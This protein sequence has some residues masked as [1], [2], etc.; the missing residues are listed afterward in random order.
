MPS[1][2]REAW[3][4]AV[5]EL[6]TALGEAITYTDQDSNVTATTALLRFP[7]RDLP[8]PARV[9]V[10]EVRVDDL[11]AAPAAGDVITRGSTNYTVMHVDFDDYGGAALTC[12]ERDA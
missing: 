12:E 8:T 4:A 5:D 7:A 10:A 9:M 3:L 2:F 1:T 6:K 11:P